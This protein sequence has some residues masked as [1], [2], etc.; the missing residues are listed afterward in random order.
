MAL[1]YAS[2]GF[3]T[4]METRSEL[5]DLARAVNSDPLTTWTAALNPRFTNATM[6][7]IKKSLGSLH[8]DT[9]S[10]PTQEYDVKVEDL[11][12]EFDARKQWSGCSSIAEI[13]D[14][15][16]CGSC[17]AI[18]SA[19]GAQDRYCIA[20]QGKVAPR[21]STRDLLSCCTSCGDGCNGGYPIAAWDYFASEGVVTGSLYG[22]Y[23]YCVS[24]PMVPCAHHVDGTDLPPCSDYDY[25]TPKCQRACDAQSSYPVP[26]SKDK[27]FFNGA[28]SVRGE[29]NMMKELVTN[30]PFTVAFS[31]TSDFLN[32]KSGIYQPSGGSYLGGHAVRL[33][34]Y[35]ETAGVKWWSIANS[36]NESWGE[37]GL[38][39]IIRGV[40]ACSIESQGAAGLPKL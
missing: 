2:A 18:S 24:Y 27:F 28:Y 38:F 13:G 11:P 29:A 21:L 17:W 8:M 33:V 19:A 39:R 14:Q 16:G 40:D 6:S 15:S 32:Y 23:T 5:L 10:F 26:Y 7:S 37:Q 12:T 34:G 31:V 30:G 35:G 36:W 22:N 3:N 25:S 20:S 9:S 4:P 1:A